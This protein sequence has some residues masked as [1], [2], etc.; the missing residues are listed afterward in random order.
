MFLVLLLGSCKK[1]SD[2]VAGT[3][4]GQ[5]TFSGSTQYN[6]DVIIS[7]ISNNR[8]SVES[9]FFTSYE[10]EIEKERDQDF[11]RYFA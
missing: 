5:M 8:I 6:V 1:Y 9:N 11:V 3:Y 7:E 2:K 10:V 4:N